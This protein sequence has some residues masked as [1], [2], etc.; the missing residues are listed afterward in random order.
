MARFGLGV[1]VTVL[2]LVGIV[3]LV[4]LGI[5]SLGSLSGVERTSTARRP[6]VETGDCVIVNLTLRTQTLR[7][8]GRCRPPD[9]EW[10]SLKSGNRRL[11]RPLRSM[12]ASTSHR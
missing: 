11:A 4:V 9:A 7:R 1:V 10:S 6:R 8:I 12:D 3:G 5:R 2:V